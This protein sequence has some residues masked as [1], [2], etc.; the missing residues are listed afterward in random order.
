MPI[1]IGGV[2][3][4]EGPKPIL[5]WEPPYRAGLYAVMRPHKTESDS[6]V[7]LYIGE[8][9]NLS[10]RGFLRNHHK[11][12]CWKTKAGSDENLYIAIHKMPDSTE[13]DRRRVEA[14]VIRKYEEKHDHK[15]KCND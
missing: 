5:S 7:V 15:P 14:L 3:F 8:S 10:E 9:G 4:E 13:N 6:F 1:K 2:E 12:P 11:Y